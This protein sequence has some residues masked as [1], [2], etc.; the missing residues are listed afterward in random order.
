VNR[1][2]FEPRR[3]IYDGLSLPEPKSVYC[4]KPSTEPITRDGSKP[5]RMNNRG[6]RHPRRAEFF[7]LPTQL[8]ELLE[9]LFFR[10]TAAVVAGYKVSRVLYSLCGG[11][12]GRRDVDL[13]CR[14]GA[15]H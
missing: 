14:R 6:K 9:L 11:T 13:V 5:A 12:L 7:A 2:G 3:S 8:L 10:P 4:E 15:T 1:A